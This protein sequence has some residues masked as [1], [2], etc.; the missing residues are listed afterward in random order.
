[1]RWCMVECTPVR[2][3]AS[4]L[5]ANDSLSSL[6]YPMITHTPLVYMYMYMYMHVHVYSWQFAYNKLWLLSDGQQMRLFLLHVWYMLPSLEGWDCQSSSSSVDVATGNLQSCI[7][8]VM[9]SIAYVGY[10]RGS[11]IIP[12]LIGGGIMQVSISKGLSY[13]Q[14]KIYF[15]TDNTDL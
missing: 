5:L 4:Y 12:Y 13:V 7:L 6:A 8:L 3:L 2:I 14:K 10:N 11:L 1:M 15:S 9:Y